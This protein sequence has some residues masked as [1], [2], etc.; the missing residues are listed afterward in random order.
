MVRE[1]AVTTSEAWA[2]IVRTAS[3][4][5]SGWHHH[6]DYESVIYVLSGALVMESGPGG[7]D[8]VEAEPGD[9]LYV[10]AGIVHREGNP[11]A[12]EAMVVLFRA[13]SG[14]TVMNVEGPDQP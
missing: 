2:G 10:P 5:R 7:A 9:F 14:E 11:G 4:M 3:G 8:V 1:A 13:G 12:G 6:G